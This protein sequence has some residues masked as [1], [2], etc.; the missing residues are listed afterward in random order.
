MQ[1]I[2]NLLHNP[3]FSFILKK[4][5]YIN[6]LNKTF[7][8]LFN[9]TAFNK[10]CQIANIQSS[11]LILEANNSAWA[12]QLR[13]QTPEL[14][15]LLKTHKDFSE[16]QSLRWQVKKT[17]YGDPDPDNN[18][19]QPKKHV[20]KQDQLIKT[21]QILRANSTYI[22]NK[23]LKIS[24]EKLASNINKLGNLKENQTEP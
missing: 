9:N 15:A 8:K 14:L 18:N 10:Y 21:A 4:S 16:I 22:K 11:C 12:T 7:N 3:A 5:L 23:K 2:Q 6:Q 1:N 24:M 19:T 13:Y 20:L 17:A